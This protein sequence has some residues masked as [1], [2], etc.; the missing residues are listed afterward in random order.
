MWD[1]VCLSHNIPCCS[2]RAL[3]AHHISGCHHRQNGILQVHPSRDQKVGRGRVPNWDYSE[4]VGEQSNALLQL[5]PLCA[6]WHCYAGR[7]LDSSSCLAERFKFIAFT[8]LMSVHIA[9]NWLWYIT[10]RIP[11]TRFLSSPR[12]CYHD[13]MQR[14]LHLEFF[15][16]MVTNYD[17]IPLIVLLSASLSFTPCWRSSAQMLFWAFCVFS[18]PTLHRLFCSQILRW[19]QWPPVF[20]SLLQH[21]VHLLG[22]AVILN[23]HIST[24][25]G[26]LLWLVSHCEPVTNVIFKALKTTDPESNS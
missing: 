23:Q 10:A 7:W 1:A 20:H 26:L 19:R 5:S 15:F 4:D 18:A 13:F 24:V 9:L 22:M 17:A 12:R 16:C 2:T 14:N 6:V 8:S 25:F 21:T 3:Q 11:L